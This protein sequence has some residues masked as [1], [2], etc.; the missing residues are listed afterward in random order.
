MMV[1]GYS[2]VGRRTTEC[3]AV[4]PEEEA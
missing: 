2:S 1:W 4:I 3:G